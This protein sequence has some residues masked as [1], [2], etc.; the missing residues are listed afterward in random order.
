MTTQKLNLGLKTFKKMNEVISLKELRLIMMMI[1]YYN[2]GYYIFANSFQTYLVKVFE[3]N[4]K[5]LGMI[6]SYMGF[7]FL[8]AQLFIYNPIAKYLNQEKAISYSLLIYAFS[9]V[10]ILSLN[11]FS[12]I[13]LAL[14]LTVV[15]R[16]FLQT[17]LVT[18]V[19]GKASNDNQGKL[20]G[21]H[22]S[23]QALGELTGPLLGGILAGSFIW[24]PLISSALFMIMAYFVLKKI[25][26]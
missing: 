3:I 24:A 26:N 16:V 23:V 2:V 25:K 14:I 6:F 9:M 8:V 12:Y 22:S 20:H 11:Q 15:A 13:Y 17:L 7:I 4:S 18:C 21:Y 5:Q 1:F 19:S 10:L